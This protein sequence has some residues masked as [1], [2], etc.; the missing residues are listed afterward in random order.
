MNVIIAAK[1]KPDNPFQSSSLSLI[2]VTV[3]NHRSLLLLLPP[4]SKKLACQIKKKIQI[5]TWG[6]LVVLTEQKQSFSYL[7][8]WENKWSLKYFIWLVLSDLYSLAGK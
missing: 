8:H 3:T 7:L 2:A 1:A 4:P 6:A 5:T